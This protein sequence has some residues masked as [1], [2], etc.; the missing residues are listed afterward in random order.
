MLHKKDFIVPIPGSRTPERIQENLSAADVELTDNEF[1]QI[2]VELAKIE[3]HGNR[4]D[5]DRNCVH[6]IL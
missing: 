6:I 3:I 1:N 2:E 5:E 4:T